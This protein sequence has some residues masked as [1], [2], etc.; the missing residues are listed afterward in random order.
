MPAPPVLP[1]LSTPRTRELMTQRRCCC[2]TTGRKSITQAQALSLGATAASQRQLY[3]D[4]GPS[5]RKLWTFT[6]GVAS[7][8]TS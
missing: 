2:G 8:L 6:D 4:T 1:C 3:V 5:V 7:V